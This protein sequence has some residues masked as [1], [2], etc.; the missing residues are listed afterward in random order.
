[1]PL[2]SGVRF[3]RKHFGMRRLLFGLTTLLAALIVLLA[4]ALSQGAF[5]EKFIAKD[6]AAPILP[7]VACILAIGASLGSAADFKSL[8]PKVWNRIFRTDDEGAAFYGETSQVQARRP[9]VNTKR[10]SSSK[11]QLWLREYVA[12]IAA[13]AATGLIFLVIY[14]WLDFGPPDE[15][16]ERRIRDLCG[17]SVDSSLI[18]S[19]YPNWHSLVIQFLI[20][21]VVVGAAIGAFLDS[22]ER[23]VRRVAGLTPS[24]DWLANQYVVCL[25][26]GLLWGAS[27]GAFGNTYFFG[28]SDGRP[29]FRLSSAVLAAHVS[30]CSAVALWVGMNGARLKAGAAV[31]LTKAI[32][33]TFLATFV[34]KA[35]DA[36]GGI[37][38]AV[39]CEMYSAWDTVRNVIRPGVRAW[40]IAAG[41]GAIVG[42]LVMWVVAGYRRV[43]KT[44]SMARHIRRS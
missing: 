14:V 11:Y 22:W 37:S 32:T 4:N 24:L 8:F 27:L 10:T 13:G 3:Q 16:S 30:V 31:E 21:G 43:R 39:Y 28:Q 34:F 44:T 40:T 42:V 36:A 17:Y 23:R 26:F 15:V 1:M 38:S 20:A 35:L 19:T 2:M 5:V 7:W 12:A 6:I 18:I 9:E 29:F 33:L 25:S 41:Y